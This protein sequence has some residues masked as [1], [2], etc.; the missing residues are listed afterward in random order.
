MISFYCFIHVKQGFFKL[1]NHCATYSIQPKLSF[2]ECLSVETYYTLLLFWMTKLNTIL[3][4]IS[5]TTFPWSPLKIHLVTRQ[6]KCDRGKSP[7]D[8]HYQRCTESIIFHSL[9][10]YLQGWSWMFNYLAMAARETSLHKLHAPACNV[11]PSE[12]CQKTRNLYYST[13]TSNLKY[14]PTLVV[15]L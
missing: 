8:S 6:A 10:Y 7:H 12:D 4:L 15:I 5:T 3:N 11:S 9:A 1:A 2:H 13:I 14:L